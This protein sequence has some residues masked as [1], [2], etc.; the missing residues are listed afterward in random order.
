VF[1]RWTRL[2]TAR[3]RSSGGYGLGLAIARDI[4]VA[5]GGRMAISDSPLG[6]TRVQVL[7]PLAD[8][9]IA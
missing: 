6:G 9:N 4:A 2:D 5:H 7:L 3:D 1:E 8:E